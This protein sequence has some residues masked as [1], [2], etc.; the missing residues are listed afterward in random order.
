MKL[1][2][3]GGTTFRVHIGGSIVVVDAGQAP[4]GIDG[5]ELVSGADVVFALGEGPEVDLATWRPRKV[6]RLLDADDESAGVEHW[7]IDG[8]TLIEVA[9]EPP[10]LIVAANVPP[11]GRWA[12]EAVV[13][14]CGDVARL[15]RLALEHSAP[16]LLALAGSDK[17]IDLAIP[18]LRDLLDGTGL[19]ALQV[20]MAVEV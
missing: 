9:G 12:G 15:G 1:T 2:W 16:R 18:I 13:V 8:A 11:L 3:F 17:V 6:A 19:M 4:A 20:G 10:L 14:V 7:H 5:A